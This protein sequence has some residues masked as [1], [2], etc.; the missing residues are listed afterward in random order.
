M[1]RYKPYIFCNRRKNQRSFPHDNVILDPRQRKLQQMLRNQTFKLIHARF[2]TSG[3][4]MIPVIKKWNIPLITSFHGFD[5]PGTARMKRHAKALKQLFTIGDRFTVPCLAMKVALIEHGCPEDK[6]VVQYSGIDVEKFA[7]KE[8][9][10]PIHGPVRIVYVGR[11]VEKKGAHI[12]LKA[13]YRLHQL[14]PRT[15][16]TLIGYGSALGKLKRMCRKLRLERHVDFMGALT[17][18]EVAK[19]LAQ[20]HIFCLPS[21]KDQ[22]GNQEGIPNAIKEAMACGLPVVS[23]FHAG[24]PELIKDGITG[25]LVADP[26]N[27]TTGNLAGAWKK[28]PN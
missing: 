15:R 23:T 26:F 27:H 14:I 8:R 10:Y 18:D 25:H 5:S 11:L 6:V 7:Y 19:Q 28:C 24:I 22:T 1:K 21:M 13:F 20:S 9:V 16:L 3:I 17:H 4:R 12:L 2:A